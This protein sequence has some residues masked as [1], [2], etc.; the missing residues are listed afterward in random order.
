MLLWVTI[1][2]GK[3]NMVDSNVIRLRAHHICCL[4]FWSGAMEGR[5]SRFEEKE[6]AT[7]SLMQSAVDQ[8]VMVIE[9]TDELCSEC[10]LCVDGRCTSPNGDEDAVRKWDAILLKELGVDF[11]TCLT[12][13]QWRDLIEPKLPYKLCQRCRWRELCRV[14]SSL[15]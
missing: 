10:P 14:G 5:G 13:R 12:C 6:A 4:P 15:P 11:N 8:P 7:K 3:E 1:L 2:S 9:G